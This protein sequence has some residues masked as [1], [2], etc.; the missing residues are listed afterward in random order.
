MRMNEF[1]QDANAIGFER[2]I[3]VMTNDEKDRHVL[4]A[5][6]AV[7]AKVIVTSNLRDFPD[8]ALAPFG[9]QALS[10]DDFLMF[11]FKKYSERMMQIITE[12]AAQLK[13]PPKTVEEVLSDLALVAPQFA[14]EVRSGLNLGE[15]GD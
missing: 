14:A 8:R 6:V 3:P 10:P 15:A 5:A 11:L 9:I 4:A 12:Q 13:N 1:F 2:L 7:K